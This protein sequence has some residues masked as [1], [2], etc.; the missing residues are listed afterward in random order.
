[1]NGF[2]T[3]LPR[4]L[5]IVALATLAAAC[6]SPGLSPS[7]RGPRG[8]AS[9]NERRGAAHYN[10]GVGHLRQGRVALAIRDLRI[11]EGLRPKDKWTQLALAD[12]Y[13]RKALWDL[14]ELHLLKALD[15]APGFQQARLTLSALYIEMGRFAESAQQAS[16]LVE[17]PTFPLPWAALTNQGWAYYKLGQLSDASKSLELATQYHEGYW[18]A[19]LNLGI[20][21]AERGNRE[22]AIRRFERVVTL[23]PGPMPLAEANYRMGEIYIGMGDR[24]RAVDHLTAALEQRPSGPWGKRSEEHLDR[25]R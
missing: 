23:R 5:L 17:D 21:E 20:I 10:L 3:I 19:F 15:S 9:Q 12:A 6:A 8:E 2:Q 18:R 13:R 7:S 11:A 1:M 25:L 14:C 22:A 24:E 16:L 4:L